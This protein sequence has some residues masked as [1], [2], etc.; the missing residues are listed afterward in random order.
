[1]PNH[2]RPPEGKTLYPVS[3]ILGV[4]SRQQICAIAE[5]FHRGG[6]A[7]DGQPDG[8]D[9][10]Q[11]FSRGA[12]HVDNVRADLVGGFCGLARQVLDLLRDHRKTA[13]SIAGASGLNGSIECEQIGLFR[14]R[15]DQLHHI[16]NP[17]ASRR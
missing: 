6:R 12:L 9:R 4:R 11:R 8:L 17:V 15:R 5:E 2:R 13:A 14:N 10:L 7:L 3:N 16:P 1:M